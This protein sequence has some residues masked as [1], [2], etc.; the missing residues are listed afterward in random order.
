MKRIKRRKNTSHAE[1]K[2]KPNYAVGGGQRKKCHNGYLK[3]EQFIFKIYHL[4]NLKRIKFKDKI[5]AFFF[6]FEKTGFS[7]SVQLEH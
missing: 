6:F 5:G 2:A 1:K 3:K 4:R 7:E